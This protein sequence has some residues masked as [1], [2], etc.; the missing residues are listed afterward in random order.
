MGELRREGGFDLRMEEND[1]HLL[2]ARQH[3]LNT[4]EKLILDAHTSVNTCGVSA[5]EFFWGGGGKK[6]AFLSNEQT[7]SQACR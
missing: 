1:G 5:V 3:K 4:E 6:G 7:F 2:W